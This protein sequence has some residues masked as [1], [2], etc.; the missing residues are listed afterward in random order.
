MGVAAVDWMVL[1]VLLA[2]V[3]LGAWRGLLYEVLS[4]FA[5]IAA[6]VLGQWLAPAVAARLP[7]ADSP[8][9]VR[10]AA[11]FALVFIAAVFAGGLLA[12]LVRKMVEAVGLRP[13]DRTLGMVFGL[14]RGVILVLALALVV[15]MT[16]A[17]HAG[18]WQESVGARY[19]TATLQHLKPVLP[20]WISKYLR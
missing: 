14:A 6:F 5:W 12:W 13:I 3:L 8:E 1:A 19:A 7:M 11:G 4:V 15:G 16:P 2:S 9:A 17:Q 20:A 18:W 10:Y